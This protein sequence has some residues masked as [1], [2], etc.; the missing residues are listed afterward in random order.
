MN[1]LS[2][3][4]LSFFF[5]SLVIAQSPNPL[6]RSDVSTRMLDGTYDDK[7][8]GMDYFDPDFMYN[9]YYYLGP[10][11]DG[12]PVDIGSLYYYEEGKKHGP[13]FVMSK[14]FKGYFSKDAKNPNGGMYYS[15]YP[16]AINSRA[17]KKSEEPEWYYP[18]ENTQAIPFSFYT[19]LK[20]KHQYKR[21]L[22][23]MLYELDPPEY[24]LIYDTKNANGKEFQLKPFTTDYGNCVQGN[25][26]MTPHDELAILEI[27]NL[28]FLKGTFDHGAA[29]GAANFFFESGEAYYMELTGGVPKLAYLRVVPDGISWVDLAKKDSRYFTKNASCLEGDCSTGKGALFM[30]FEK[31]GITGIFYGEFENDEYHQGVLQTFDN[32]E[33]SGDFSEDLNGEFNVKYRDFNYNLQFENGK[34]QA[35]EHCLGKGSLHQQLH[36]AYGIGKIKKTLPEKGHI[37]FAEE[38]ILLENDQDKYYYT[39]PVLQ[40]NKIYTITLLN[41]NADID[42]LFEIKS[43]RSKFTT[44]YKSDNF[45]ERESHYNSTSNGFYSY[46]L[47]VKE[48]QV[49]NIE[50]QGKRNFSKTPNST[51]YMPCYVLIS[52]RDIN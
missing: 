38:S 27:P 36:T 18:D 14:F 13:L 29:Y 26:E 6:M 15:C 47:Y 8:V 3:I 11:N 16:M 24:F 37:V 39:T 4:L 9:R 32:L 5:Y 19:N 22:H 10:H 49:L 2:F 51:P 12:E 34:L 35:S 25:C 48:A 50:F 31:A 45:F 28:G 43:T 17:N 44:N 30:G 1:K 46:P 21:V 23:T 40:P 42:I 7:I 20:I 41:G 52:E 33:I